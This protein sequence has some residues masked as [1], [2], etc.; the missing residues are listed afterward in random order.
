MYLPIAS[1]WRVVYLA[2]AKCATVFFF[3]VDTRF[4]MESSVSSGVSLAVSSVYL[5][6]YLRFSRYTQNKISFVIIQG[7]HLILDL[8]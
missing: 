2:I 7:V 3:L 1:K 4:E 5:Q 6:L 8:P